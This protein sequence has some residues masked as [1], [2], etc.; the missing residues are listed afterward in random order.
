MCA[1]HFAWGTHVGR[2][3][4]PCPLGAP[5]CRQ[6]EDL[7]DLKGLYQVHWHTGTFS[8]GAQKCSGQTSALFKWQKSGNKF[9]KGL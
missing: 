3:P 8:E 9:P 6:G 5:I 4:L 2:S 1:R 7:R